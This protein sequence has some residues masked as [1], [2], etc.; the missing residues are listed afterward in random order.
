MWYSYTVGHKNM[1]E[2]T[3][4]FLYP[5]FGREDKSVFDQAVLFE[6][7]KNDKR[8]D[9]LNRPE[10][11]IAERI[12]EMMDDGAYG[13]S[14]RTDNDGS[15]VVPEQQLIKRRCISFLH[16]GKTFAAGKLVP[17]IRPLTQS[18]GIEVVDPI[19]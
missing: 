12:I 18:K 10:T 4:L 13:C 19:V 6:R 16:F 5:C 15:A 9:G 8:H 14:V 2:N 1:A 11:V 7:E 17:M 3:A